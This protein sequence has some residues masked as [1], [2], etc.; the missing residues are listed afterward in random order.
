MNLTN[1]FGDK[2]PFARNYASLA[3]TEPVK[4]LQQ[5]H[6]SRATYAR[7][8]KQTRFDG[9]TDSEI[10]FIANRDSFY[11]ASMGENGFPYIQH[12]GGPKGFLHVIDPHTLGF[13]DFSGNK[14]YITVGNVQTHPQVSLILVDYAR[15]T[16]LKLYAT[17]EIV[18]LTDRPDLLAQLDPAGY[19]HRPERMILLHVAAFDWNCPQHITPRYTANE[20]NE[21]LAPQRAYIA[22][23]EAEIRELRAAANPA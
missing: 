21:V 15:Q 17:A 14:Q 7:V 8:E 1:E 10:E 23:L 5:Q 13:V 6:G 4:A 18:A 9:L 19:K 12:R 22:Q 20:I 16:R 3:F 2:S 11:I